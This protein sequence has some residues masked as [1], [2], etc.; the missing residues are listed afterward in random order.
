[1]VLPRLERIGE[2]DRALARTERM[3]AAQTVRGRITAIDGPLFP[4]LV[5]CSVSVGGERA[6]LENCQMLGDDFQDLT[7][8]QIVERLLGQDV[9]IFSPKG[10]AGEHY[11]MG[12]IA[13]PKILLDGLVNT[14]TGV[15][16]VDESRSYTR[17]ITIASTV[18]PRL[19]RVVGM[20]QTVI[21]AEGA[22]PEIS[23]EASGVKSAFTPNSPVRTTAHEIGGR[24]F[25]SPGAILTGEFRINIPGGDTVKLTLTYGTQGGGYFVPL[26]PSPTDGRLNPVATWTPVPSSAAPAPL[27]RLFGSDSPA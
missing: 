16:E 22:I 14:S 21:R 13:R 25:D 6:T 8:Q 27:L 12:L 2:I 17:D 4:T 1:M 9:L 26:S 10:L 3:L 18:G 20:E 24:G 7:T 11:I 19:L 15:E 23:L 5:S